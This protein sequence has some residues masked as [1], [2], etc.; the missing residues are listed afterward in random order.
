[1]VDYRHGLP[2][3]LAPFFGRERELAAAARLHQDDVR[4]VTLTGPPGIGKTT[5]A[6]RLLAPL[7][8]DYRDGA[9][10]VWL[11]AVHDP[12]L[13]VTTIASA[14]GLPHSR[15]TSVDDQVADWL[16]ERQVLLFLDNFGR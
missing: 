16:S 7:S 4:L 15:R 8:P 3:P 1:M 13:V 2:S 12:S 14:L 5:L 10:A 6:L 11:D 9:V